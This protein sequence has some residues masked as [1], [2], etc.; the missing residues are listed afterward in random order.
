MTVR[1]AAS[2]LIRDEA[3]RVLVVLR[4]RGPNTGRWSLPGGKSEPGET[5][6]QTVVREVR[7]ETG[8]V[9]T[10]GTQRAVVPV[11][12]PTATYEIHVFE[13]TV[14]GGA[15]R[16]GD[17]AADAAWVSESQ[18]AALPHTDGLLELLARSAPD[19]VPAEPG[20]PGTGSVAP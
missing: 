4:G 10:A 1:V 12:A 3:G 8:L 17:D 6:A 19:V 13:A 5:P 2:A 9:I 15:V 16:A 18:L 7:E 11:Q 14:L 20:S